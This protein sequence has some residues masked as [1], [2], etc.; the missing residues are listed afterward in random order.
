MRTRT[1]PLRPTV[2]SN[3]PNG[4]AQR[5]VMLRL[6]GLIVLAVVL[7]NPS[8]NIL[9]WG[10]VDHVVAIVSDIVNGVSPTYVPDMYPWLEPLIYFF[11]INETLLS[12]AIVAF[13]GL[14]LNA[15]FVLLFRAPQLARVLLR[16][17]V[18]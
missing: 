9:L 6:S 16:R 4:W 8:V 7:H 2:A 14:M 10:F 5:I 13:V 18:H 1:Q 11:D 3:W 12:C 15:V 17:G